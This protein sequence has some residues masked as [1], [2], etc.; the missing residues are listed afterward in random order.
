V[1]LY[2]TVA[3]RRRAE[4]WRAKARCAAER[5]YQAAQRCSA[6]GNSTQAARYG[7]AALAALRYVARCDRELERLP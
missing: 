5:L 3:R 6:A 4:A 2:T 1:P 7:A